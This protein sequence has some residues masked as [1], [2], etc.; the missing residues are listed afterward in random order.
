MALVIFE[1]KGDVNE[2]SSFN[3]E[4]LSN[5][6]VCVYAQVLE[7]MRDVA[8]LLHSNSKNVDYDADC[9]L[10]AGGYQAKASGNQGG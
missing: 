2:P 8:T 7:E 5:T 6:T 1:P 9:M 10:L 4:F 3:I